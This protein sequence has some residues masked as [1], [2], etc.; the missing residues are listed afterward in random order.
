MGNEM[1]DL[2]K[3]ILKGSISALDDHPELVAAAVRGSF[4]SLSEE[5]T[6][7]PKDYDDDD[8]ADIEPT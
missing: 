7:T 3:I 8:E 4:S 1:S 5:P 2:I 6:D